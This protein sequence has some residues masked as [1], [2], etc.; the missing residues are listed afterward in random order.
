MSAGESTHKLGVPRLRSGG[1]QVQ[2]APD[3]GGHPS[4]LRVN[5]RSPHA[6][7]GLILTQRHSAVNTVIYLEFEIRNLR[8][9]TLCKAQIRAGDR[10]PSYFP[11]QKS[12][13]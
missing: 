5:K 9:R 12:P 13:V 4:K 6:L 3:S 11:S 2:P 1:L 7:N 8:I 10:T